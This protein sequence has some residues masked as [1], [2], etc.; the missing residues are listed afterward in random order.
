MRCHIVPQSGQCGRSGAG[1]LP[2]PLLLHCTHDPPRV[3]HSSSRALPHSYQSLKSEGLSVS[4]VACH[5]GDAA[6]LQ[7]LVDFALTQHGKIDILVSNAAVNPTSGPIM[8]M[9]SSAIDK[10]LDINGKCSPVCGVTVSACV[11][12]TPP[13]PPYSCVAVIGNDTV[14]SAVILAQKAV[15]HIPRGG[16]ITFVSSYSAF[17]PSAPIAMYAVSK[18]AL[19]GLTKALAEELGPD[20]IRV[21]CIAPGVVPTKFASALVENEDMKAANEARTFLGQ[22]RDSRRHGGGCGFSCVFRC[23]V[24]DGRDVGDCWGDA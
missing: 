21:N 4:G 15:P 14:R 24:C 12:I 19:L 5:V 7:A 10:I 1:T 18:T 6:Q 16:S 17:T 8:D 9:D 22:A 20:G 13:P 11:F 23:G 2:L 3:Y